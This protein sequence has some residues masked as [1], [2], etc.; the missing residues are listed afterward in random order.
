MSEGINKKVD[1]LLAN[2]RAPF[3]PKEA[4]W[5]RLSSRLGVEENISKRSLRPAWIGI[6]ASIAL[7]IGL[8]T[9]FASQ[10]VEISTRTAEHVEHVLP[11]GSIV[12]L[13]ASSVLS[14]EAGSFETDRMLSL[15]GEAFFEVQK[16]SSFKVQT[17][18]GVVTVLGTSFNVCDREDFFEVTCKTGKV[19]V[20][21]GRENITLTPGQ[22]TNNL[23]GSLSA[24]FSEEH[25]DGWIH[26][27]YSFV[28][29]DLGFVLKEV[30]R[31]FAVDMRLPDLSG[32][33]FTGEFDSKDLETTLTVICEPMGLDYRIDEEIIVITIK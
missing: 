32:R 9:L 6:A 5:E 27:Q 3:A 12:T 31:Q 14:Y 1:E 23:S 8:F 13:N 7:A 18:Q 24:A 16:G 25:T 11:D 22:A 30:E 28:E 29:D 19:A 2:M 33:I 4:S 10:G 15:D 21:N 26:G 17:D 20:E